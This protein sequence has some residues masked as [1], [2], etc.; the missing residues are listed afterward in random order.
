MNI[1]LTQVTRDKYCL[2]LSNVA[3]NRFKSISYLIIIRNK[4][5]PCRAVIRK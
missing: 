1:A 2:P 4:P 3:D 5:T